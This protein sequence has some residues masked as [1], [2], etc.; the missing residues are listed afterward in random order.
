MSASCHDVAE[1]ILKQKGQ[2]SA[3]KLQKLVFY[4]LAWHAVWE[5]QP[6]FPEPVE[7]W[8]NGPVVPALYSKH[9]GN[10]LLS[11]GMFG[12]DPANLSENEEES[13]DAVLEGYFHLNA[14]QLSDLSHSEAP[15]KDAREGLSDTERGSRQI[16]LE[17]MVD[18]YSS[19]TP[20]NTMV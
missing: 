9:K 6:L 8:I 12:G 13:I 11:S 17:A 20:S 5:E 10:W 3:M 16:T 18:Y 2:V 15:W 7:A 14:Q 4:S 19:L 1:Y